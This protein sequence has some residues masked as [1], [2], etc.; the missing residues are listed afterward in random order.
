[1]VDL[2]LGI[3]TAVFGHRSYARAWRNSHFGWSAGRR[4]FVC[5]LCPAGKGHTGTCRAAT[6][7]GRLGPLS[8]CT[9]SN[10][11]FSSRRHL[12]SGAAVCGL[13]P[14]RLR[15]AVLV[16]VPR[17]RSRVRGADA[18]ANLWRGVR[19]LLCERSALDPTTDALADPL[20]VQGPQ[21]GRHEPQ[22][23]RSLVSTPGV[24]NRCRRGS[25]HLVA[26]PRCACLQAGVPGCPHAS[27][28]A[29]GARHA[30]PP[31]RTAIY[32]P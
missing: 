3:S 23:E 28:V 5:A 9:K 4:G 8:L 13:A 14:R 10:V 25:R 12:R 27:R 31:F 29:A 20:T 2:A 21:L 22:E 18:T 24:C 17:L 26:S 6:A 7:T 11:H 19:E 30:M 15:R 32:S 16:G 1:M